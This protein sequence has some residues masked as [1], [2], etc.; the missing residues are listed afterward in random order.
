[1]TEK[2]SES[3]VKPSGT[4]SQ[5][6][7][8]SEETASVEPSDV[9]LGPE[10]AGCLKDYIDDH[11][12]GSK[13]FRFLKALALESLSNIAHGKGAEISTKALFL[14]DQP[15]G[16]EDRASGWASEAWK[17]W[18]SARDE[19]EQGLKDFAS[20]Q[21]LKFYPWPERVGDGKGGAGRSR[22]YRIEARPLEQEVATQT[23][24]K[25]D[26]HYIRE[27]TPKAAWWARWYFRQEVVLTGWR[28][29]LFLAP[30]LVSF[31]V[32]LLAFL[33]NWFDLFFRQ[34]IPAGRIVVMVASVAICGFFAWGMLLVVI[35]L[36][37]K[38]IV[39]AP[40]FLLVAREYGV[41]LELTR[42]D[43]TP[44]S[45]SRLGL[46]R[47]ATTCP[48]C[49]ARTLLGDGGSEFHGRLVGRCQESP[50]EHVFSFDRVYRA[51]YSLRKSCR[52]GT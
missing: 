34:D 19:R 14:A 16:N 5:L 10:V 17:K 45:P 27:S 33:V 23:L 49:G 35:R 39:M 38:R 44:D 15:E 37:E 41:Q 8:K 48:I 22:L 32:A 20:Q 46:V 13:M 3:D 4:V 36:K 12:G 43:N 11:G 6:I 42:I 51:G 26:I 50:D 24:S 21:G 40:E 1:M 29:F 28:Y 9:T 47:Y 25:A 31:A 2:Q 7:D 18:E 52:G 30:A